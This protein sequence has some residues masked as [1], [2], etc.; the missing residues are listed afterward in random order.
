M[1]CRRTYAEALQLDTFDADGITPHV[2]GLAD[3]DVLG[4]P[5]H[6]HQ[7]FQSGQVLLVIEATDDRRFP[8]AL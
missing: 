5:G 1:E 3:G 2:H 7:V 8:Y 6:S 4:K